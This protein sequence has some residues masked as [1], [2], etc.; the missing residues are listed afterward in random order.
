M[1]AHIDEGGPVSKITLCGDEV[2]QALVEQAA[3]ASGMGKGR[4]VAESSRRH[5]GCQWPREV[6]A[7]VGQFADF[8]LREPWQAGAQDTPRIGF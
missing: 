3:R 6:L 1:A 5:A 2:T 7:L 8:P 4:R